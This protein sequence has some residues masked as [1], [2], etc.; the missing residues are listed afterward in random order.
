MLSPGAEWWPIILH[1]PVQRVEK[2]GGLSSRI[3]GDSAQI[4][5]QDPKLGRAESIELNTGTFQ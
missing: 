5:Q 2:I 3:A 4:T 1:T